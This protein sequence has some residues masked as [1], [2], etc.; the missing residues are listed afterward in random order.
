MLNHEIRAEWDQLIVVKL[1]YAG[2]YLDLSKR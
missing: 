1:K 2:E